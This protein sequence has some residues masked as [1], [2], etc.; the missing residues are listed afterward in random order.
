MAII[1]SSLSSLRLS[2]LS[3]WSSLHWGQLSPFIP[4]LIW[5]SA[6]SPEY[7]GLWQWW[8]WLSRPTPGTSGNPRHKLCDT[9]SAACCANIQRLLSITL[10]NLHPIILCYMHIR[11][12]MPSYFSISSTASLLIVSYSKIVVAIKSGFNIS[13]CWWSFLKYYHHNDDH[14]QPLPVVLCDGERFTA[15]EKGKMK[16]YKVQAALLWYSRGQPVASQC[17]TI[18]IQRNV[19]SAV[20]MDMQI[21]SPLSVTR[22]ACVYGK[23]PCYM[24]IHWARFNFFLDLLV[25]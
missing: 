16:Q 1:Q 24:A 4:I 22:P 17:Y 5:T 11:M 2:S 7:E 6:L 23:V 21:F 9:R 15:K 14:A 3:H 25:W 20:L 12:G 8:W 18:K 13:P 19:S 10:S